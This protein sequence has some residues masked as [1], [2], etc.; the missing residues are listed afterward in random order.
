MERF[1][2]ENWVQMK[3][4]IAIL[5][6]LT[7]SSCSTVQPDFI[8]TEE[9]QYNITI[10]PENGER[11]PS[12]ERSKLYG[13]WK[14][15][16]CQNTRT[17]VLIEESLVKPTLDEKGCKVL[18]GKWIGP[19]TNYK[20]TDPST[21]QI[22]H[23][24]P[25]AEAHRSGASDWTN[26]KRRLFANDMTREHHLIA[27]YGPENGSKSAKDLKSYLPPNMKFHCEYV[28]AWFEIKESWQ[29]TMDRAEYDAG[30]SVLRG[31]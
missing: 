27:V 10:A 23:L 6:M 28:T 3:K 20:T 12:K 2:F 9:H 26:K 21:L 8:P 31:C 17:R 14:T 15:I 5:M 16:K 22:D 13:S 30:R 7:V 25:L 1:Q 29:L 11:L 4:A 18:K 24:V 19:F